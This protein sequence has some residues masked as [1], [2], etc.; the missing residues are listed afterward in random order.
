MGGEIRQQYIGRVIASRYR[1]DAVADA[2]AVRL[3]TRCATRYAELRQQLRGARSVGGNPNEPVE[4][5]R[6]ETFLWC[7]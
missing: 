4:P 1:D 5:S 2:A 7:W 3:L 6:P